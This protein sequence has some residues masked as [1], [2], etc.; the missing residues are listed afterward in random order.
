MQYGRQTHGQQ[1]EKKKYILKS[2]SSSSAHPGD[3]ENKT[4]TYSVGIENKNEN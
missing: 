1:L 3:S 4:K 2:F